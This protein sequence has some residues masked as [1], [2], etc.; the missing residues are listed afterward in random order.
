[1]S[2][3]VRIMDAL[4]FSRETIVKFAFGHAQRD[5]RSRLD[6]NAEEAHRRT[7]LRPSFEH[8]KRPPAAAK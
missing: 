6:R 4:S 7:R 3:T 8:R 1:V 5:D 2:K